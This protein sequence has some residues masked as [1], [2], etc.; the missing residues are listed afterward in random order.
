MALLNCSIRRRNTL[1]TLLFQISR[2]VSTQPMNSGCTPSKSDH[3]PELTRTIGPSA[4]SFT[5]GRML[6]GGTLG[7]TTTAVSLALIFARVPVDEEI[8]VSMLM[9]FLSVGFI[10]L[11]IG[12]DSA[13]MEPLVI[14]GFASL[15]THQ[16][17]SGHFTHPQGPLFSLLVQWPRVLL[18]WTWL[19]P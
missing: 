3:A 10:L 4:P 2:T 18:S 1:W 7:S 15:L 13:R 16:R 5:R 19:P 11:S 14:V 12:L 9:E 8:C 17:S 6:G